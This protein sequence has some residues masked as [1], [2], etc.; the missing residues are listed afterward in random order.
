MRNDATTNDA[1][2]YTAWLTQQVQEAIDD[3]RPS[4]PHDEVMAEWKLERAVLTKQAKQ[5]KAG[6]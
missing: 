5:M 2:A 4:I 1:A 3:P 6:H